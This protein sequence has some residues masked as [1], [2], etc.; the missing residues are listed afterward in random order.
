LSDPF[1]ERVGAEAQIS[2]AEARGLHR[3]TLPLGRLRINS[4]CG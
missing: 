4:D 3:R 1:R 2:G